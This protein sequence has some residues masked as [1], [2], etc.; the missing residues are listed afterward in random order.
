MDHQPGGGG[1]RRDDGVEPSV[2]DIPGKAQVS[3]L[4]T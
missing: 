4:E 2:D 1:T 3:S